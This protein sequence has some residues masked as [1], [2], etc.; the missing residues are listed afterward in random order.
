MRVNAREIGARI[1]VEAELPQAVMAAGVDCVCAE[2]KGRKETQ[3]GG[4]TVS[5]SK[6]GKGGGRPILLQRRGASGDE[7]AGER[8]IQIRW[9]DGGEGEKG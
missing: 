5:D 2:K 6:E 7:A 1:A 4:S 3:S 9:P 8:R